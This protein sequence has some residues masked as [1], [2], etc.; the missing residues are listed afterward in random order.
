MH[1]SSSVGS[2]WVT[3]TPSDDLVKKLTYKFRPNWLQITAMNIGPL[4]AIVV[5]M[6]GVVILGQAQK[7]YGFNI[8]ENFWPFM[9][10]I[11]AIAV[12]SAAVFG[13]F[14][15]WTDKDRRMRQFHLD[16]SLGNIQNVYPDRSLA[17]MALRPSDMPAAK[18]RFNKEAIDQ[19]FIECHAARASAQPDH[20]SESVKRYRHT[21][22]VI[23]AARKLLRKLSMPSDHLENYHRQAV[24]ELHTALTT[25]QQNLSRDIQ[26][27]AQIEE[28]LNSANQ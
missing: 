2:Y 4:P 21:M 9:L 15:K 24:A 16:A 3:G 6:I 14:L 8:V 19:Y 20:Y 17:Y 27:V 12:V 22:T 28:A 13:L 1:L 25:Q 23:A 11:I 10:A 5:M 18:L 26:V 7:K